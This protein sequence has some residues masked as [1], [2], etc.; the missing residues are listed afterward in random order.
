MTDKFGDLHGYY[1]VSIIFD[2]IGHHLECH[3]VYEMKPNKKR[4][5][6]IFEAE[7]DSIMT[8][9]IGKIKEVI[10]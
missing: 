2:K 10:L 8:K 1:E 4:G 9:V 3:P 6:V 7:A 5:K